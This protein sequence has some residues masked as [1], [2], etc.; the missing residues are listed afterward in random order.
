MANTALVG[1]ELI[2]QVVN[3]NKSSK[4]MSN[5]AVKLDLSKAFD[6]IYWNFLSTLL[7]KLNCHSHFIYLL[8]QCLSTTSIAVRYNHTKTSYFQP[9][10]GLRQGDPFSS[11]LLI[12]CIQGMTAIINQ[13]FLSGYWDL[14]L[15]KI[16]G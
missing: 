2:Y 11:L 9:S 5:I 4:H 14:S 13:S 10:R 8:Q 6:R 7:H 15:L 3:A 16:S 12:I 1:L